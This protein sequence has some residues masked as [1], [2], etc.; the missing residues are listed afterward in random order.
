MLAFDRKDVVR[1]YGGK[2][3]ACLKLD[4]ASKLYCLPAALTAVVK[5]NAGPIVQLDDRH[6]ARFGPWQRALCRVP[7]RALRTVEK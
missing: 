6:G 7:C 2:G 5:A 3:V 4:R 1:D